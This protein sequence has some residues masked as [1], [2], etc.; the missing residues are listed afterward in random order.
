LNTSISQQEQIRPNGSY[1]RV[2]KKPV[3]LHQSFWPLLPLPAC[4]KVR[5]D[6]RKVIR[7]ERKYR[8]TAAL[9]DGRAVLPAQ[10]RFPDKQMARRNHGSIMVLFVRPQT[11][12]DGQSK[13]PLLPARKRGVIGPGWNAR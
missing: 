7:D 6:L 13:T 4:E 11:P 3:W 8:V 5:L 9:P 1:R 2:K 10:T 12:R